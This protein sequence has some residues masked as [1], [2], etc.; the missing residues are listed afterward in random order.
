MVN[1]LLP[2]IDPHPVWTDYAAGMEVLVDH[3]V[4]LGHRRICY[5]AG[6]ADSASNTARLEGLARA[7]QTH[8]GVEIIRIECGS[9]LDDGYATAEAALDT[10]TTATM[11]FN[12]LVALGLL[13]RL[14]EL[15][16]HVPA[17]MSVTGVDDIDLARFATPSL[18]TARTPQLSLGKYAW[19]QLH[20]VIDQ[21]DADPAP[22]TVPELVVRGST[23]PP[24]LR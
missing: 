10:G 2:G 12:D 18:T 5:L 17:Q 19:Q 4:S 9:A 14:A 20:A 24:A 3:L 22:V 13:A 11:A 21:R 8:P 7:E 1:R 23:G 16:V 6:P 15:S